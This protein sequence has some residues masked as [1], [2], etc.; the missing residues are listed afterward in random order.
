[1]TFGIDDAIAAGLTIINKFIPDPAQREEAA[2]QMAQL[3][4]TQE[5]AQLTADT[6]I[7]TAQAGID[8]TEAATT[9]LFDKWRDIIGW[10]C[11]AAYG[12]HFVLQPVV[13][14]TCAIFGHKIELP[15]FDM[16]SL[17]T[18]LMGMLGLGAMH[19]YQA[20]R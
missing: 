10:T 8:Q 6:Q 17:N 13:V 11:G 2:F 20:T 9:S 18:V 4:A 7:A 1:M 3:K 5:A 19:T 16:S 15:E 12:W 14:F